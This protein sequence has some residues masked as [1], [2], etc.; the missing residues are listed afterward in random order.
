MNWLAELLLQNSTAHAVLVL[1][2]VISVGILLGKIRF[3]GVSFG[4]AGVLFAG[5][6]AA[7]FQLGI[8]EQIADFVKDFGL[9]LFVYSIGLQVGPGFFASLRRQGMVINLLAAAVVFLGV[10][11]AVLL[12]LLFSL[13][14]DAAV[15]ILTGAVTNTPS[16][17]AAQQA[18]KDIA[19]PAAAVR[20]AG[21]G[22][23]VAYP[24]GVLGVILAMA[25]TR[26]IF[27][28]GLEAEKEAFH[29]AQADIFPAPESMNLEVKN[30]QLAGQPLSVLAGVIQADIVVSR[31]LRGKELFTPDQDTALQSGDVLLVV[32]QKSSLEKLRLLVGGESAVD[33][34]KIPGQLIVRLILVSQ[35]KVIGRSLAELQ[36]RKRY[37]VN[38]TRIHRA[39]IEFVPSP[40]V[41]LQFGDRLTAVG[42]QDMITQLAAEL[43]NSLK[44]LD[45]PEILPVFLGIIA[46]VL[47]GSLPL[48]I[49]GLPLPLKL[50]LAGGPLVM[51]ILISRFGNIGRFSAYVPRSANLMLREVG[52]VLF[53]ACVGL[54][55]G[56][57]FVP[58]VVSRHGLLWL[59]CGA[60]IT[61]LPLLLVVFFARLVLK[62]NYLE[63][64]GLMAGSM[65]DPP[66]LAFANG[67][68]GS[69]APAV[70]YATVY[71]LVTFLR[72][73]SAQ[74]LV[75]FFMK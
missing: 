22:Y 51:A 57:D 6:V 48:P 66:A 4:I 14:A 31:I 75:L 45:I 1:A 41:H 33:L 73:I 5:I 65:T 32:G 36:L 13:P 30:P 15:G 24:F 54:R 34:K 9:I 44:E 39:G 43:G 26:R 37:G 58:T 10:A 53:L 21:L 29:Q 50:G 8:N 40:G 25:L 27:R 63:L 46:G 47:L 2:L 64:C 61:L 23:A 20:Q 56:A 42:S 16:L 52:I 19:G 67:Y 18:L 17:G 55:A 12:R 68:T 71:P 49:P 74:V 69:D 7:H 11:A 59:G 3:F 28:I 72:I 62:K 35:K 38:I 70:T 60:L